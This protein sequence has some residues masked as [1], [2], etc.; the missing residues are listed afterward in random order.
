MVDVSTEALSMVRN[1]LSEYLSFVGGISAQV[2]DRTREIEEECRQQMRAAENDREESE[3]RIAALTKAIKDLEEE[4][5]RTE[6]SLA[7]LEDRIPKCESQIRA[8]HSRISDMNEQISKLQAMAQR[9]EDGD[10][11]RA[12]RAQIS[13]LQSAVSR[14][15]EDIRGLEHDLEKMRD[16]QAELQEKRKRDLAEKSDLETKRETELHRLSQLTDKLNRM[17]SAFGRVQAATQGYSSAARTFE[18]QS[19]DKTR[20]NTTAVEHCIQSIEAYLSTNL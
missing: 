17:H 3:L 10:Q 16:L 5:R 15:E 6:D 4:I 20:R 9:C 18:S 14:A 1:S 12:I 7:V 8:T 2:L 13:E 11:Q 19:V